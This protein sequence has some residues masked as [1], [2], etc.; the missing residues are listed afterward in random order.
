MTVAD[1]RFR[2]RKEETSGMLALFGRIDHARPNL[3]LYRDLVPH[4]G[5]DAGITDSTLIL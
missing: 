1:V 2:F 3:G 4:F 5:A